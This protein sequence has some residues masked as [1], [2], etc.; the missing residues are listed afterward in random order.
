MTMHLRPPVVVASLALVAAVAFA[1]FQSF[2]GGMQQTA[3][4]PGTAQST[5][6]CVPLL[7]PF[8]PGV[9]VAAALGAWAAVVGQRATLVWLGA[10]LAAA[11]LVVMSLGLVG[12]AIGL[13]LLGAGLLVPRSATAARDAAPT[14]ML[15]LAATGFVLVAGSFRFL[16]TTDTLALSAA[17][18]LALAL[19]L[20]RRP[21]LVA[22]V[23][24]VAVLWGTFRYQEQA[25]GDVLLASFLLV[26][27]I[28]GLSSLPKRETDAARP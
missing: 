27:G 15:S 11:L 2:C 14:P 23:G 26:A 18:I 22:L 28:A 19:A 24:A 9:V 1:A 8:M 5:P 7:H 10:T 3:V 17:A 13:L 12:T 4:L 16:A 20:A 6:H 25:L 21:I